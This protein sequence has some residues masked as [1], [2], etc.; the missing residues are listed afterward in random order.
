MNQVNIINFIR[1]IEPREPVDLLEPVREQLALVQQHRLPAT[2]LLQ[3]DA[4]I[5]PA[6]TQLL[7]ETDPLQEI[8]VW[9]EVVQPLAEKAGIVWR[10]RY[11]WDWYA[12]VGFSVGYTPQER[13]RLADVLMADFHD[14]FGY[15][16][17][18][19]G[20]W[21]IDAHLLAYLSDKYAITASCN[22][23][24]QWGTDG[25]TLWGGYYNQGYYP[26]KKNSFM[27]AQTVDQQIPVPVFRMLGSDP[28]YQYDAQLGTN[29]QGVVTLEPVYN[30]VEGGGGIPEWVRWF[31]DVNFR[32]EQVSFGYTQ[33]GQENSFGWARIQ[34]GFID[35]IEL[36][37]QKQAE[38]VLRVATLADTGRWFK[39]RY[40]VTPASSLSALTDWKEEGHQSIWYYSRY[41]R[42][43][44]LRKDDQFHMRDI[45]RYD[46]SYEERYL[47][48]VCEDRFSR[49][50]TLPIIDGAL[51]SDD[52]TE[53][54]LYVWRQEQGGEIARPAVL[55]LAT[56]EGPG[57]DMTV[58]LTMA[59]ES[60]L[61]FYFQEQ[62]ITIRSTSDQCNWGLRMVWGD[63]PEVPI[64]EGTT[65]KIEYVYNGYSYH[66]ALEGVEEAISR[67]DGYR[68][69]AAHHEIKL[70]F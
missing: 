31:F 62:M 13:E 27:P 59:D 18:S 20:S 32:A 46:A 53:A 8:G 19:V 41:Y 24:D 3:Y 45:H 66:L 56:H 68:L 30:G 49:Y 58:T 5:D 55:D 15:Y 35:Q 67:S 54:G 47:Q 1:G 38:G 33:V 36:L 61:I 21:F 63:T 4:L 22:C 43:N 7:Q 69:N 44:L 50:D 2:W 42:I 17:Q 6:F 23:K 25:Y 60:K 11:A 37:A 51:W 10:G 28:I 34:D 40:P 52:Q 65:A 16:P 57:G 29:G 70:R 12:H 64:I 48:H 14:I 39:R 9:F 26:S